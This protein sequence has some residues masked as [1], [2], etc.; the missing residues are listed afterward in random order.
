MSV[1]IL[2][3]GENKDYF[4]LVN[5]RARIQ[6]SVLASKTIE[7]EAVLKELRDKSKKHSANELIPYGATIGLEESTVSGETLIE[8]LSRFFQMS[9]NYASR[10]SSEYVLVQNL[11][12][13]TGSICKVT[14]LV[15]LLIKSL[16]E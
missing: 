6:T 12:I 9:V 10:H 15:Q 11:E 7:G 13:N 5:N 14:G 3:L 4:E 16:H 1:I 2:S 8:C